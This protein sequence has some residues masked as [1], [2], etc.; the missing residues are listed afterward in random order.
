MIASLVATL[1][2]WLFEG[3]LQPLLFHFGL[4]SYAEDVFDLSEWFVLGGIEVACLVV[5]LGA[6]ERRWPAE[7]L[8]DRAAVRVDIVYTLLHRLG[9]FAFLAFALVRPLVDAVEASLRLWGFSRPNIDQ[10]WPGVTDVPLVSFVIYLLVLDFADYWI[11][12]GQHRLRWWWALHA[13]HHSQRQ[14]TFWSDSRNHVLDSLLRDLVLASLSIFVGVEPAQFVLLV[15]AVRVLESLQHA[16]L[17]LRFAAPLDRLLVSP[18]FHRLHHAI[19]TGHEGRAHGVNF[20]VIFPFWDR[21]FGTADFRPGFVPTGIRDQLEGR[22]Y[23]RGFWRQ[24]WRGLLRLGG[25]G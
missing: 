3:V 7:P 25:R 13:V 12:R 9:L 20:A 8:V 24:Q 5:V 14:M 21:L 11:H 16:N 18:S 4:M 17:R 10:L 15:I 23:G 22:D 19:G 2:A 6:L 1:Q